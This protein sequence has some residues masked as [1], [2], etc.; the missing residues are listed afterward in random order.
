MEKL[1]LRKPVAAGRFYPLDTSDLIRQIESF[2]DKQAK[3]TEVIACI[4]PHAGYMYS[5][6]VAVQTVSNIKIKERIILLGPNHTGQG[7]A[8][9][10]MTQGIWQT[11][12]GDVKVDSALAEK[13]LAA[14]DDLEDDCHAHRDE[15]SLEVEL[16]ILQYCKKTIQIVPIC[17]ASHDPCSLKKIGEAITAAIKE[18]KIEESTLIIA[19]SDMTHYEPQDQADKKDKQAIQAILELNND[20]LT[21]LVQKLNI[22][23]CGYAP[24]LVTLISS[25]LLG[26]EKA[27]LIKY[28]TS[29]DITGDY[30]SVVGYAGIII[31]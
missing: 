25:K 30:N 11:P 17:L 3:K 26:A 9:S 29:G 12:L 1:K 15:H 2:I 8:F 20:K 6:R 10:I 31:Y 27:E 13:I 7:P 21:T 24:V 28:Q 16:P 19:S 18:S 4:L 14:S 23:M 5:G 22:S